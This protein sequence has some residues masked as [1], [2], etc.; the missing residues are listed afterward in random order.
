MLQYGISKWCCHASYCN[1]LFFIYWQQ[2]KKNDGV[3][4]RVE[5]LYDGHKAVKNGMAMTV[6]PSY[7]QLPLFM[8]IVYMMEIYSSI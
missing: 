3:Q 4:L 8:T 5:I 6:L 1:Y 7:Q 2:P